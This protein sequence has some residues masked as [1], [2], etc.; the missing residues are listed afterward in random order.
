MK[1]QSVMF[2]GPDE[3]TRVQADD[4]QYIGALT[5]RQEYPEDCGVSYFV[6]LTRM[7]RVFAPLLVLS[8]VPVVYVRCVSNTNCITITAKKCIPDIEERIDEFLWHSL[9]PTTAAATSIKKGLTDD[10]YRSLLGTLAIVL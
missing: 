6:S 10:I 7:T 1:K 5:H 9:D 2:V 3:L 4:V 8:E